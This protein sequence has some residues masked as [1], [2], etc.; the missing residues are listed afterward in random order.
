MNGKRRRDSKSQRPSCS[1]RLPAPITNARCDRPPKHP[2]SRLAL[3]PVQSA[4]HI[5]VGGEYCHAQRLVCPSARLLCLVVSLFSPILPRKCPPLFWTVGLWLQYKDCCYA[6]TIL[7]P[8]RSIS[9]LN[10]API[11]NDLTKS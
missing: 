8:Y 3:Q 6:T 4:A 5:S 2:M 11:L 7:F 1:K 10:A 9:D